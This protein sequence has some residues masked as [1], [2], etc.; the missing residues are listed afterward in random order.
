MHSPQLYC[1]YRSFVHQ[2][3]LWKGVQRCGRLSHV[4]GTIKMQQALNIQINAKSDPFPNLLF[5]IVKL[6]PPKAAVDPRS[7]V[8]QSLSKKKW[9]PKSG[10]TFSPRVCDVQPRCC[11]DA[12]LLKET[13]CIIPPGVLSL[14]LL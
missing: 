11:S 6:W 2:I 14:S 7:Q 8:Q 9:F 13:T 3:H 1:T 10:S 12:H 5:F 4:N